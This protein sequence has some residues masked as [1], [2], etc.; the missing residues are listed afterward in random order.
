MKI[1]RRT[2]PVEFRVDK[3]E[4]DKRKIKGHAAV[5]NSIADLG[6]FKEMV[7]PGA[8]KDSIIVDDIRALFNHDA[9]YVLGR[10]K[11]GTLI[12]A[13]DERGLAVDIEPPGTQWAND[14]ITS[15][16]RGDVSQMSFGFETIDASWDV[17]DTEEVRVLKRVKLWDVSVVTFPAYDQTDAQV[18]QVRSVFDE[19]QAASKQGLNA[20]EIEAKAKQE[21][22]LEASRRGREL[23]LADARLKLL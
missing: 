7:Q 22:D 19:H 15:M 6:W 17:I 20:A 23:E 18:R 16:E 14:L 11:P 2:V 5:F 13:E 4:G 9:N 8:F 12:L 1:E 10:N 21:R 3:G